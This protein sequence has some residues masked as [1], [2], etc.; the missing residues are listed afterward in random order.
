MTATPHEVQVFPELLAFL[1]ESG[2]PHEVLDG[3]VVVNPPPGSKHEMVVGALMAQLWNAAPEDIE[4][5]GSHFG[6]WYDDPSYLMADVTVA[7]L[8]DI[9]RDFGCATAGR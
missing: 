8:V 6:F 5:L 1:E 9:A 4:V 3:S 2:I 7:R